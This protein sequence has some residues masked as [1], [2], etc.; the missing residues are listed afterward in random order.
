MTRRVQPH[1]NAARV[2]VALPDTG[3]D[4]W[5][6]RSA[7]GAPI[8]YTGDLPLRRRNACPGP[9]KAVSLAARTAVR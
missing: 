3:A 8:R 5:I 9:R 6:P 2:A 4:R 1:L 7:G